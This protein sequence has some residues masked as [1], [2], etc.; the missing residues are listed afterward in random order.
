MG[1]EAVQATLKVQG[2]GRPRL[3]IFENCKHTVQEITGY[4]WAEG[5]ETRDARDEPLKVNDHTVDALRYAIFG[6]EG[7]G[8]FSDTDL[9]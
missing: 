5:T 4:R 2:D 9:S 6:V 3:F 1:I 7:K 8:Y